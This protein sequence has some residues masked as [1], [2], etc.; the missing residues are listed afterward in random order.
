MTVNLGW[1]KWIWLNRKKIFPLPVQREGSS[2][3]GYRER[4][5]GRVAGTHLSGRWQGNAEEEGMTSSWGAW[6]VNGIC[7]HSQQLPNCRGSRGPGMKAGIIIMQAYLGDVAGSVPDHRNKASIA[8]K[9]ATYNLFAPGGSCLPFVKH[10]ESVEL[11]QRR[12][13]WLDNGGWNS[14]CCWHATEFILCSVII[15]TVT[16]YIHIHFPNSATFHPWKEKSY[17]Y[18][19]SAETGSEGRLTYP[20]SFR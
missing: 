2:F 8:I 5:S 10:T 11:N 19:T 18:L 3:W 15:I 4:G 12:C 16:F 14:I 7:L 1:G 6:Q 17:A 9:Q 20:Q 13:A